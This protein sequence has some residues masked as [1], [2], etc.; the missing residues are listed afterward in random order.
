M[1][2]AKILYPQARVYYERIEPVAEIWGSLDTQIDGR[3]ENPVTVR[4]QFIGFHRIE[5]LI[6][7]DNTLTGAPA[8]C[9]GLVQH[10]QQLLTLVAARSTT[11]WKWPAAP[12]T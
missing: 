1:S 11:R 9:A 8:L 3:W 2:Q 4:S 10:E 7:S 12:P 5:Q 6:W